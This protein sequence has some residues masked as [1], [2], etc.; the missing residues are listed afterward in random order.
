[1]AEINQDLAA[2][3]ADMTLDEK[4][5]DT[6]KVAR[7]AA[8]LAYDEVLGSYPDIRKRL[9]DAREL[10]RWERRLDDKYRKMYGEPSREDEYK[11]LKQER[12]PYVP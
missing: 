9:E 10:N 1:M 2:E 6:Y 12:E 5:V 8:K 7:I 11:E 4:I 3:Q